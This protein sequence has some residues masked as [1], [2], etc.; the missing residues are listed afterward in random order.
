MQIYRGELWSPLL[1][2]KHDANISK[3]ARAAN[4]LSPF[5]KLFDVWMPNKS[6]ENQSFLLFSSFFVG[7]LK[8]FERQLWAQ[9]QSFVMP[10]PRVLHL[11]PTFMRRHRCMIINPGWSLS[12]CSC[13]ITSTHTLSNLRRRKGLFRCFTWASDERWLPNEDS[14]L[15]VLSGVPTGR[16]SLLWPNYKKSLEIQEVANKVEKCRVRL[17]IC[18]CG[19]WKKYL[20]SE[21][22]IRKLWSSTSEE[23]LLEMGKEGWFISLLSPFSQK[24]PRENSLP[25]ENKKDMDGKLVAKVNKFPEVVL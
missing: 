22:E 9:F 12:H 25:G 14:G 2:P 5:Y 15:V 20:S 1:E 7:L 18:Q 19:W 3:S 6:F 21:Q 16:P 23:Q 13:Q 10:Y 17:D 8:T 4:V 24:D 11:D